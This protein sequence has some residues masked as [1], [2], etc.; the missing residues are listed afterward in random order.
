[1]LCINTRLYPA[2]G[3]SEHGTDGSQQRADSDGSNLSR[4]AT[5]LSLVISK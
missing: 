4:L 2:D 1:M 5:L 3:G